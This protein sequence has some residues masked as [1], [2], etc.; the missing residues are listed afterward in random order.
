[1][2]FQSL[3]TTKPA[4]TEAD[5]HKLL[6]NIG[7]LLDIPTG[8]Y[9]RGQKGENILLGG[10]SIL[11]GVVGRGNTFKSTITHYM[12]LSAANSVSS[13]GVMP[14][15]N[16]YDTE[17]NIDQDRLRRFSQT[18]NNFK[19]FDVIDS[20][21]WSITD[22]TRHL[23]DE[24]YRLLKDFLKAEK[25][26]NKKKYTLETPMVDKDL[27]P[28]MAVFPT[29]GE[30]DSITEFET[31]D[32]EEIQN[33]NKL[34]ESGGNMIHARSGL[35]KTRLLMELPVICNASG[36]YTLMTA[37]VG[38]DMAM[39]QGP[40]MAPPPKKL[41][42]MMQGDKIKGVTDK[43]FFLPTVLWQTLS[44]SLLIND[45]TK[46]PEYPKLQSQPDEGS[47]DLNIVKLKNLRNK[48]GPTGFTLDIVV[49]QSE[50]VLPTLTEFHFLKKNDRFGIEGSNINYN[51]VLLPDVKLMRTTVRERIDSNPLL[52][53]AIK[54]TA[55]LLQI[56]TFYPNLP[57]TIPTPE[58]LYAKLGKT[59]DWNVL[60]N[61]RDYWTF[62]EYKNPVPFLS[63]MDLVEMYNDKYTPYWLKK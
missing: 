38:A 1:M 44:A 47:T 63:T 34:G 16:T 43:F 8:K 4:F 45:G 32:I 51:M 6:I 25:I 21:A 9:V 28:I 53:R 14:Y 60:L 35:A 39:Q 54:I 20:G 62:N 52:R 5:P 50:G 40:R 10:L 12:M 61:T 56:K 49:S 59:Y 19:E 27:N 41:Q 33:K 26:K 30:V 55:D 46:G 29:F 2:S 37:H 17:I 42:H 11:T 23:G 31:S 48:F 22:K 57:L 58:E 7:S 13:S 3:F 24:W 18:F 15:M 36:H